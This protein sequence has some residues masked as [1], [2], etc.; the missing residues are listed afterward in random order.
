[1]KTDRLDAF[2]LALETLPEATVTG[3]FDNRRYMATKSVFN[4]GKSVKFVAEELGGSDYISLN[5]YKLASGVR[6]SPCEM[7]AAKVQSFV[8]GFR[9]DQD[10]A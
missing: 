6:L 10:D 7:S 3:V 4:G 8:L 9:T 2:V 5:L 1:M